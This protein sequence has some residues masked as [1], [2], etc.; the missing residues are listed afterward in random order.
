MA[1]TPFDD[2]SG[3]GIP[4]GLLRIGELAQRCGKTVRALHLYEDLGLLQPTSRSKGRFRLYDPSAADR[5]LWI[6]KLQEMGFSLTEIQDFL[7]NWI[8]LKS[9]PSAMKQIRE[10]FRERLAQTDETL[11][12]LTAL[13]GEMEASLQYLEQCHQCT[14]GMAECEE[15]ASQKAPRL[16]AEF[17]RKNGKPPGT[18]E[19]RH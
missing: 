12:R 6:G 19:S 17:H 13:R 5:V 18:P 7:R 4:P 16:L 10:L 3:G 15:C 8:Q 2:K 14:R 11:R 1:T 9:A